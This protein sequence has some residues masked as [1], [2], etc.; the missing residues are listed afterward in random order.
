M[1]TYTFEKVEHYAQK[2]VKCSGG[3]GRTLR[4]RQTTYQTLSPF[5]KKD[6]RLK[7]RKE[8]YAELEEKAKVWREAPERCIHCPE[9]D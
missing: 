3:C 8:I 1:P 6:G 2:S 9:D 5:N 4:R 7:T